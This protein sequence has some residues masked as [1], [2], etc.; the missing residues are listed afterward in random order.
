MSGKTMQK[1]DSQ[2]QNPKQYVK[3]SHEQKEEFE[4]IV[5]YYLESNPMV[6]TNGKISE[7]EVRFNT[8]LKHSKP[9]SKID[10]DNVVKQLNINIEKYLNLY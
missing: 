9:I 2:H 3:T 5:Q 8:D 1:M 7:L 6:S 10:Y 4:R